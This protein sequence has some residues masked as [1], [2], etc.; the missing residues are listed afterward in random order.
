MKSSKNSAEGAVHYSN[1]GGDLSIRCKRDPE[2]ESS[3]VMN[4]Q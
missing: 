4:A 1:P 2:G 3:E